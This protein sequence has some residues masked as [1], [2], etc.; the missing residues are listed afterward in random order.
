MLW[1]LERRNQ[2]R[3]LIRATTDTEQD[4]HDPDDDAAEQPQAHV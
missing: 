4:R 3:D 2:E 1:V